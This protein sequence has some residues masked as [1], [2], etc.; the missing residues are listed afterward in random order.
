VDVLPVAAGGSIV[1]GHR[2][3][4]RIAPE[5]TPAAF[6]AAVAVGADGV[7]LDVRRTAGGGFALHHDERLAD[8]RAIASLTRAALPAEVADL[9]EGLDACR[10]LALV[11]VEIKNW[12]ADGD[13]DPSLGFVDAVAEAL[14]AR[15]AD[16]RSRLLVSCFHL[17]SVD[18]MREVAP[19]L[20]TAWL[21]V[22][23]ANATAPGEP[24]PVAALVAETADHGH[25]ALHPHHAFVTPALVDAAHVAGLAVN[26]WTCDDPDRIRWLAAI[27]VDGIVTNVPDV[28]RAALAAPVGS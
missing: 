4:P 22:G 24:D 9:A 25:A 2:G 23:P 14:L 28:A 20:A 15:P 26:T 17:P 7:E 6:A 8:G 19:E 1:I 10:D 11:N 3:A 16:D 27:G 5:N 21:V 13:F 12:P 18:R